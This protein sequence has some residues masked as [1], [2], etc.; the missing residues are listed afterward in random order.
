MEVVVT[1]GRG[2]RGRKMDGGEG[3]RTIGRKRTIRRPWVS[4]GRGQ[5]WWWGNGGGGATAGEA[6]ERRERDIRSLSKRDEDE[7]KESGVEVKIRKIPLPHKQ[8]YKVCTKWSGKPIIFL[9]KKPLRKFH[10]SF[11]IFFKKNLISFIVNVSTSQFTSTMC[12]T[13]EV[14]TVK[15]IKYFY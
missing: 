14:I 15:K 4:R 5:R 6:V 7:R 2:E 13:L 10:L 11:V 3:D 1:K 9:K 12:M 8:V